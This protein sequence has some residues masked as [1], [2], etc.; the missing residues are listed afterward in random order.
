MMEATDFYEG[1]ENPIYYQHE[2][3]EWKHEIPSNPYEKNTL[4]SRAQKQIFLYPQQSCKQR[5]RLKMYD[6][7]MKTQV[8]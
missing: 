6:Y 5:K 1:V 4:N 2:N 8:H 7:Y 3:G